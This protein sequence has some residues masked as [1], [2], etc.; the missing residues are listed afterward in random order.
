M[1]IRKKVLG[2]SFILL[3]GGV[4]SALAIFAHSQTISVIDQERADS[5]RKGVK[6]EKQ[7]KH[8]T[9]I[10]NNRGENLYDLARQ[11]PAIEGDSDIDIVSLPGMPELSPTGQPNL[12][13]QTLGNLTA[14]ADAIV[15]GVVASKESQLTESE[16][17]IF[18]DYEMAIREVLK[19]NGAAPINPSDKIT[20]VRP[21]GVVEIEGR[22]VRAVDRTVKP[23][24]IGEQYLLFLKYIPTTG[25]YL[26]SSGA[27]S[28][29]IENDKVTTLT[30]DP[31]Y[32]D[33]KKNQGTTSFV[34]EIHAM[35]VKRNGGAND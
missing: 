22:V 19:D 35:V 11:R 13:D 34:N 14:E 24:Q 25:S 17:F 29:K 33:F 26:A 15:I 30:D 31:R 23:L 21:G 2:I 6:T 12:A 28:F 3:I 10:V 4:I 27:G 1:S 32:S 9:L 16:T 5:V 7:K 8:G 18:T 20:V